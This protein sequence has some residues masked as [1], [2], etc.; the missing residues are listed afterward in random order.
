MNLED[1]Y[2]KIFRYCYYHVRNKDL[3]EDLTQETFLRFIES[4]YQ[5]KGKEMNYLYTIAKNLCINEINKSVPT[6]QNDAIE[7]E[8]VVDEDLVEKIYI[9]NLL[10]KLPDDDREVLILRYMNGET[11]SDISKLLGISR[12]A[13]YRKIKNAKKELKNMLEGGK[14]NE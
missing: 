11:V 10:M 7:D 1:K 13:L 4:N 8:S 2:N 14:S 6:M 9:R 12:F 5:E 3:A